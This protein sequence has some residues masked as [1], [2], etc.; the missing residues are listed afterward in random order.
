VLRRRGWVNVDGKTWVHMAAR[1]PK[2]VLTDPIP[3]IYDIP[4]DTVTVGHP[5]QRTSD[6]PGK[7]TPAGIVEGMYEPGGTVNITTMTT[8]PYT[9]NHILTLWYYQYPEFSVKRVNL[10][11]A[12]GKKTKLANETAS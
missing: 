10:L 6:I 5:G 12:E 4:A 7:F 8:M 3:F 1:E 2:D 11:D 9:V